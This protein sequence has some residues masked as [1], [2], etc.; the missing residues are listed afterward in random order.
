MEHTALTQ[1][2]CFEAD[3]EQMPRQ[4]LLA[5]Q[6]TLLAQAVQRARHAPF[7][8]ERLA[9]LGDV[10]DRLPHAQFQ[11]GVPLTSKQELREARERAWVRDNR[12]RSLLMLATSGTT[13]TRIALPYSQ[14]DLRCWR[15]Y[16]AR[17]LWTNGLR[18]DD[19][20]LLPVPL[21]LFTGG[22]GM[23]GGLQ[24][25]GCPTIPLGAA[26]TPVMLDALRGAFGVTPTGIVTLPSHMLRLLDSL[27][28]AGY[29]PAQSPLR[30]GSFGAEAWT[31]AARARIET[32][33]GLTAIDSYGI[34][35]IFGPGVAAECA[36]RNGMHIWEDAVFAEIIDRATGEPVPD[37]APGELVLTPLFREVLPLLRYR[38]GDEA[39]FLPDTCPCGRTHRRITRIARRL[40]DV[41]VITGMNVDPADI[42]R[43]LYGLPWVGNEFYL[44]A[45]GETGGTLC[46]HF[47]PS[48]RQAVPLAYEQ[49][50][51]AA[52]RADYHIRVAVQ[53]HQPGELERTPG[54]ARRIR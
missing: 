35:E 42:E 5:R 6:E 32:G 41:L 49:V 47:E 8:S 23:L 10:G 53:L 13:G 45:G 7:F 20:V 15:A 28:A 38:T 24:Q 1:T 26:T 17:T 12:T 34:G 3:I 39:A 37:G 48:G 33:F 27:P 54:K 43:I 4:R 30:I 46:V 16:V 14:Q 50:I 22:Q 18:P 51:A 29:D 2:M 52:I 44:E 31:E 36:A 19:V 40:D 21:G 25:L 9:A 11:A